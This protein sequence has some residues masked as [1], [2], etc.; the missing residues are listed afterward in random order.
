MNGRA[1]KRPIEVPTMSKIIAQSWQDVDALFTDHL[2]PA[3]PVLVETLARATAAGLP[4]ISVSPCQGQ[5]LNLFARLINARRILELGTLAGYSTICLARA[6]AKIPDARVISLE[7]DPA[8]ADLARINL[9]VAAVDPWTEVRVGKAADTLASMI[10]ASEPPFD[11]IFIDADKASIAT[12]FH[13][14]LALSRPGTAI[15]IDNV[16]RDGHISSTD[17]GDPNVL[18]IRQW[19]SLVPRLGSTISSTALQTVGIKG[20]D[21]FALILINDPHSAMKIMGA[22]TG[23]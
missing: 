3:D 11:L 12:Y 15:I 18:G 22:P 17:S 5:F 14:S 10:Q 6:V 2:L 8:Y 23:R 1:H 19:L 13:L 9:N 7:L 21:G 20:Y 16:V 4:P